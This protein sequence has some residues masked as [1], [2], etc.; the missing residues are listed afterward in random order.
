MIRLVLLVF[1]E[2][3]VT[4]TPCT[5]DGL[6]DLMGCGSSAPGDVAQVGSVDGEFSNFRDKGANRCGL[7]FV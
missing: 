6:Y 1:D 5:K 4:L 3:L 7:C 2:G